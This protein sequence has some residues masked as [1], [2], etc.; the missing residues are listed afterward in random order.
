M[1]HELEKPVIAVK[2][3]VNKVSYRQGKYL[4]KPDISPVCMTPYM[5]LARSL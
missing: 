5:L 2:M 3:G 1:K 4:A